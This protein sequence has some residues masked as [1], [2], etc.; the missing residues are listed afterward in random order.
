MKINPTKVRWTAPTE[1]TDGS[2]IPGEINYDIGTETNEGVVQNLAVI[3]GELQTGGVYEAPL[4]DFSFEPGVHTVALRATE[5]DT[6][7]T[8]AWSNT[9]QFEIVDAKPK[10]PLAV[11]VA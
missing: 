5:V 3:V 7:L 10:A 6:G 8:S 4:A 11:A 9:V 2:T 1:R